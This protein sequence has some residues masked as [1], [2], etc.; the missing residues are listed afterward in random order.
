MGW[1]VLAEGDEQ[2]QSDQ[3]QQR[4][5]YGRT[6]EGA[7]DTGAEDFDR[8]DRARSRGGEEGQRVTQLFAHVQHPRRHQ[9]N[10]RD[11]I[12]DQE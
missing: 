7:D 11:V 3:V 12:A 8:R 2:P 9:A 1:L 6:G 4:E 10:P 5:A